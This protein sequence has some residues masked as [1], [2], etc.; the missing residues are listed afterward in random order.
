MSLFLQNHQEEL[1]PSNHVKANAKGPRLVVE[2]DLPVV[3]KP[4]RQSAPWIPPPEIP[5]P[6][7][8]QMGGGSRPISPA[9]A[10]AA[11]LLQQTMN[12]TK[13][14]S[15]GLDFDEAYIAEV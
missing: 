2:G 15:L 3:I 5:H 10:A 13:H 8:D 14:G 12:N 7:W 6:N 9:V 11:G 4:R 1:L